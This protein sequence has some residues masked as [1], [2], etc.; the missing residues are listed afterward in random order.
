M[1][2][3]SG[4]VVWMLGALLI[5]ILV[6]A[7]AY[8]LFISPELDKYATAT[9]DLESAQEFNDLLDTQILAA[10]TAE[11]NVDDWYAEIAAIR[12][13]LPPTPEQSAFERLLN[14]SLRAQGLPAVSLT[15]GAPTIVA[16]VDSEIA[17]AV[18]AEPTD[19]AS[20]DAGSSGDASAAP[21]ATPEPGADAVA[22]GD[23]TTVDPESPQ[24]TGLLET[25]VTITTEGK[26][27]PIMRFLL[28]MQTQNTRF[29]TVTNFDIRRSGAAEAGAARPALEEG[30]WVI[31]ITGLV[32][33][34]F[35][36]ELSLPI[37]EPATTPP[38]TGESVRNV[39]AP[40][41]GTGE[42]ATP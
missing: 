41:P 27:Q 31:T 17:A 20:A 9:A 29:F 7:G 8:F 39:F 10:Q 24:V 15:Y 11:K 35:D 42:A 12:I 5:S 32:F 25:P 6:G 30:D 36:P 38:Y 19:S 16:P 14:D 23:T 2:N 33:N 21:S 40:I 4:T 22:P 34:L 1:K 13:D 18:V 37:E 28:E 26:P 3:A